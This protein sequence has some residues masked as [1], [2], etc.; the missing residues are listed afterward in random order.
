MAIQNRA[1]RGEGDCDEHCT[2]VVAIRL[3]PIAA[4]WACL[5]VRDGDGEGGGWGEEVGELIVR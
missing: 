4:T 3:R 1:L 5:L 2:V